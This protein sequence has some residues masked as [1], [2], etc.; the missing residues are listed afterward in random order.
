[1]ALLHSIEK[2][3][4]WRLADPLS[5]VLWVG[6]PLLIGGLMSL[7]ANGGGSTPRPHVLVVDEDDT[8]LSKALAGGAGGGVS[9]DFLRLERVDAAEGR[10]RID[11]GDGSALLILPKGLT[12]AIL[13]D[14]PAELRL[15]TN[16]S[17]RV[18]PKIVQEGLE[19]LV[20]ANHYLQGLAGDF[21][22]GFNQPPPKGRTLFPDV[23]IAALGVKINQRIQRLEPLLFPPSLTVEDELTPKQKQRQESRGDHQDG[24][25]LGLILFPSVLFMSMMFMAQ[26]MSFDIWREKDQGTLQRALCSPCGAHTFLLSK[27]ISSATIMAVVAGAGLVLGALTFHLPL[28]ALPGALLW[29]TYGGGCLLLLFLVVQMFASSSRAANVLSTAVLFPLMMIGGTFFPFE[30]MPKWMADIGRS[31]PNGMAVT[32]LKKILSGE[33]DAGRFAMDAAF[34]AFI[35]ALLFTFATRFL[36][37][38]FATK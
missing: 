3:L 2:D 17:Q 25:G 28:R 22:R 21:L 5:I 10:R 1:M 26:G 8:F 4:R 20:E 24:L 37:S 11:D 15:V 27:V 36:R 6:I 14:Q 32:Q 34:L 12:E 9:D 35:G 13:E 18:L 38:R 23:Y 7:I 29:S 16:P 30:A 19:I 31:T 33:L